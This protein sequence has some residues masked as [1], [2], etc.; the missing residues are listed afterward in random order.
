MSDTSSDQ[1]PDDRPHIDQSPPQTL[2]AYDDR[3]EV[4]GR[5]FWDVMSGKGYLIVLAI[6]I[7]I[8]SILL[9]INR[10]SIDW[11]AIF[12]SMLA[13]LIDYWYVLVGP[14]IG[15]ILGD[16]FARIVHRPDCR[17][18]LSLDVD[19]NTVSGLLVPEQL[20]RMLNQSGNNVVYHSG[21][22]M[23]VYLAQ[24]VDLDR[25]FVDYGWVHEHDALVVFTKQR[26]YS[27][28]KETLDQA[29]AD[30]L[31]L[32]DN[33]EVY[34]LQFAGEALKRHLDRA[35][36]AVGV[37]NESAGGPSDYDA[38]P[39]EDPEEGHDDRLRT[40]RMRYCG[41]HPQYGTRCDHSRRFGEAG[42]ILQPSQS[43]E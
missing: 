18:L 15:L 16:K 14:I 24:T 34:G 36:M 9:I 6:I 26:F 17:V 42:E 21:L 1:Y 10:D 43:G 27:E 31:N 28:W 37:Q 4:T 29:M 33:P 7:A 3:R 38:R 11:D 35:A 41:L 19:T 32:M 12:A 40:S 2:P 22:G 13:M 20:F 30:N 5:T 8:V 23:P 25:G 39:S